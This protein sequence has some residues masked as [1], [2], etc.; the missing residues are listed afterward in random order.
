MLGTDRDLIGIA[1]RT[2]IKIIKVDS[3]RA[4]FKAGAL[5]A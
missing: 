2:A 5:R 3:I 4:L 1:R